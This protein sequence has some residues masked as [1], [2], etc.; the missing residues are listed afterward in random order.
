MTDERCALGIAFA[1]LVD[2]WSDDL[3]GEQTAWIEQHVFECDE[4]ARR[5]VEVDALARGIAAVVRETRFHSVVTDAI[6]NRLARD[7]FRIRTYTL[8]AGQTIPC[9]VWADD[10]LVVARI[11]ANLSG[12][13]QVTVVKLLPTGEEL[14]RLSD[15]PVRPGQSE[16]IDSFS[17]ALIRQLPSTRVRLVVSGV[18]AGAEH[19]IGEYVL[20]HAGAMTR[21]S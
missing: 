14:G 6:L 1:V 21:S 19:V 13:E 4:C 17:A 8:E 5:L 10:D 18:A 16:I 15:I 2:Y 20:E 11:R 9:A 12:F 3:Q 7:G